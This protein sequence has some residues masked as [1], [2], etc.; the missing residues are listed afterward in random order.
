MGERIAEP[1]ENPSGPKAHPSGAVC[2]EPGCNKVRTDEP[3]YS[4]IQVMFENGVLGWYSGD[5][6]EL[7][8]PHM[9]ALMELGNKRSYRY[10]GDGLD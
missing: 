2:M 6:G 3:D 5:D 10:F 4:A 9:A 8:P 7:C 1:A